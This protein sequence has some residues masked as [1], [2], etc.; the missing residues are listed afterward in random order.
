[1]QQV[2]EC[3]DNCIQEQGLLQ[4]QRYAQQLG[5]NVSGIQYASEQLQREFDWDG[6]NLLEALPERVALRYVAAVDNQSFRLTQD[7]LDILD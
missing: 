2:I 3:N 5:E 6:T 4:P 1:M 7:T